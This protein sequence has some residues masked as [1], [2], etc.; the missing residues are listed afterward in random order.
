MASQLSIHPLINPSMRSCFSGSRS[1]SIHHHDV[2]VAEHHVATLANHSQ[3]VCGLAWSPD[4][5][6][7]ASGG[8]DNV[9][10]IWPNHLSDDV[11][12]LF[13]LTH[14]QAAVKVCI[15]QNTSGLLRSG[16]ISGK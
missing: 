15:E 14:H 3:E 1:G 5:R 12:P 6:Y 8:N 7:L 16:N 11:P 4:G 9:L 2:R 10:N 13:N